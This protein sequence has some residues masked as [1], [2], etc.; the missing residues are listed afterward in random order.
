[1]RSNG[2]SSRLRPIG[3]GSTGC[4]WGYVESIAHRGYKSSSWKLMYAYAGANSIGHQ[5]HKMSGRRGSSSDR[6]D[7][8]TRVDYNFPASFWASPVSEEPA[9]PYKS[10]SRPARASV[11][12]ILFSRL[13]LATWGNSTPRGHS[14][15]FRILLCRA[16]GIN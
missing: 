1:M 11:R 15:R 14:C 6:L 3:R 12:S 10:V 13:K 8:L 4:Q 9:G 5:N 2:V 16:V 7:R